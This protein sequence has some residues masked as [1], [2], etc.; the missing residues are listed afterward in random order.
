MNRNEIFDTHLSQ[1]ERHIPEERCRKSDSKERL[2]R[3]ALFVKGWGSKGNRGIH[4]V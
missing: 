4:V 2:G 3:A 1:I